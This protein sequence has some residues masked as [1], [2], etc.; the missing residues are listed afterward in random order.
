[1]NIKETRSVCCT[2]LGYAAQIRPFAMCKTRNSSTNSLMLKT[3]RMAD[4]I[5]RILLNKKHFL[6]KVKISI[7][8]ISCQFFEPV[9]VNTCKC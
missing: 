5:F 8:V 2:L 1:M 7:L 6:N 3:N 4:L 9:K